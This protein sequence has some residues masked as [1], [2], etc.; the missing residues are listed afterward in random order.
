MFSVGSRN[1]KESH[2]GQGLFFDDKDSFQFG[3]QESS[4][5]RMPQIPKFVFDVPDVWLNS[6]SGD[7]DN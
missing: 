4:V 1:D 3:F 2:D 6:G 5:G 7:T